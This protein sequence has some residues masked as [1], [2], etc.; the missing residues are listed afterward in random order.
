V[1]LIAKR[2]SLETLY[3]QMTGKRSVVD[4][5]PLYRGLLA[6]TTFYK[7]P[8]GAE[9]IISGLD[10]QAAIVTCL[11]FGLTP[12]LAD[13]DEDTLQPTIKTIQA[14]RTAKTVAVLVKHYG[15]Y[16]CPMDDLW[17]W[18][19]A[20]RYALFDDATH[21]LP[22]K[23]KTWANGS[24]PSD[25]TYFDFETSGVLCSKEERF[26]N[27]LAA[28]PKTLEKSYGAIEGMQTRY[29]QYEARWIQY[30]TAF[31]DLEAIE[32]PW[33]DSQQVKQAHTLYPIRLPDHTP[34]SEQK[35]K[36]LGISRPSGAPRDTL[37]VIQDFLD[38]GLLLP[39]DIAESEAKK[40]IEA[41]KKLA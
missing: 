20:R 36:Q 30:E 40:V 38:R 6:W 5:D 8:S 14:I 12:S 39:L 41:I 29:D 28:R 10:T 32:L 19:K 7:I 17:A 11:S 16:P 21:T 13:V 31:G 26:L 22:L 1:T 37:P 34:F 9:I 25:F 35:L 15:G 2:P 33:G 24:W 3:R 18:C 23:Y 27:G 4:T